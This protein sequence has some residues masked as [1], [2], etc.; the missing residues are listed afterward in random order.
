VQ[1]T[2]AIVLFVVLSKVL[3]FRRIFK[4]Q[5]NKGGTRR[6]EIERVD[7]NQEEP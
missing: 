1:Q 5:Q 4:A 7:R 3:S 2:Q 6:D